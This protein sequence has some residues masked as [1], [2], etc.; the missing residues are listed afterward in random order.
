MIDNRN[1]WIETAALV[2][3]HIKAAKTVVGLCD[4]EERILIGSLQQFLQKGGT[5]VDIGLP[6]TSFLRSACLR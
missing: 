6:A 2:A 1:E 3:G 4:A 5:L